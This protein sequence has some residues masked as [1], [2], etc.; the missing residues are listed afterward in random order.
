[1]TSAHSDL[2]TTNLHR[3]FHYEQDADPGAVGAGKYWLDTNSGPPRAVWRRNSTDTGW[4]AVGTAAAAAA[5]T[6]LDANGTILDVNVITDGQFL[7]RVGTTVV[8]ATPSGDGKFDPDAPPVSP[9]AMDDEFNDSASMSGPVNGLDAKWSWLN[10]GAAAVTFPQVGLLRLAI[11]AQASTNARIIVQTLPAAPWSFA[12]K[13]S[14][15]SAAVDFADCGL[16]LYDSVNGDFY[17]FNIL[18]RTV[19][20]SFRFAV[21][22]ARYTN[23]TTNAGADPVAFELGT[24]NQVYLRVDMTGTTISFWISN[25]GIA[26]IRLGTFTDA[27]GVTRVGFVCNENN[28]TGLTRLFARWFRRLS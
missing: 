14:L 15:E 27:V 20:S 22:S 23:F 7:K 24:N 3:A 1:M 21:N 12:A 26:W 17:T 5:A 10:Q 25:D 4:D 11:A 6:Q 16:V 19:V 28:N 18:V 13:I 8:S 2:I 9:N